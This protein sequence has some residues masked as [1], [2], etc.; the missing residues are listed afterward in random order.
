MADDPR[1]KFEFPDPGPIGMPVLQVQDVSFGYTQD[2]PL[3]KGANF[4]IDMDSRIAL[5]G[6]N[7][8]GASSSLL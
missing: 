5:V 4:G 3:F 7:G 1:W 2:R 6:P 8:T